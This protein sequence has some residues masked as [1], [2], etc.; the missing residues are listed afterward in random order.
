MIQF[1]SFDYNKDGKETHREYVCLS[2]PSDKYFG[3]DVSELDIEDQAVF[4]AKLSDMYDKLVEDTNTLMAEY[5]IKF[6]Y[7][8]FKP[9]QMS[10][11]V[12]E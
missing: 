10:N 4:Y 3:V 5:D 11:I 2:E 12:K 9:E 8:Y 7:R 6:K 1:L